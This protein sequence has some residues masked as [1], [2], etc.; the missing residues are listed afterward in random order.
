MP[1][2]K[3]YFVIEGIYSSERRLSFQKVSMGLGGNCRSDQSDRS[4]QRTP[5]ATGLIFG[6]NEREPPEVRADIGAPSQV[7]PYLDDEGLGRR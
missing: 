2:D 6:R 1:L 4:R 5:F 3:R 7:T